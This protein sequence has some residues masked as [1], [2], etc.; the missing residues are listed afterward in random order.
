MSAAQMPGLSSS[1]IASELVAG[2]TPRISSRLPTGNIASADA[3]PNSSTRRIARE[4]CAPAGVFRCAVR[5][6]LAR[7]HPRT[8]ASSPPMSNSGGAL[9]GM[10]TPYGMSACEPVAGAA[11]PDREA[12]AVTRG[13]R[14][15]MAGR[16]RD[17]AVAAQDLVER[18]RLSEAHERRTHVRRGGSGTTP[19]AAASWRTRAGCDG[20]RRR[21]NSR[22]ARCRGRRSR[23][24]FDPRSTSAVRP[25]WP[26]LHTS[27]TK[28]GA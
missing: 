23:R 26:P 17:V 11:L 3:G 2:R 12:P 27:S 14:G 13:E 7:A 28:S 25:E 9:R 4:S 8:D 20:A 15:E 22:V 16:A 21:R 1:A 24:G 10:N 5:I 18:E 6:D 19:R